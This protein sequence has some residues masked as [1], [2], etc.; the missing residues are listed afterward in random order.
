MVG[1]RQARWRCAGRCVTATTRREE[2]G[3]RPHP[4]VQRE[5]LAVRGEAGVPSQR[6]SAP[7]PTALCPSRMVHRPRGPDPSDLSS[8]VFWSLPVARCR[9]RS[10][11]VSR[12]GHQSPAQS[13]LAGGWKGQRRGHLQP[14]YCSW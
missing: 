10:A 4:D 8:T 13:E 9:A 12:V 2:Q 1:T 14:F 7:A 5:A 3:L 11:T 6:G